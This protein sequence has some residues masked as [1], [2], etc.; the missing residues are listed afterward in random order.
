MISAMAQRSP[1]ISYEYKTYLLI[2]RFI[3]ESEVSAV[4]YLVNR[5]D[6]VAALMSASG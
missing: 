3:A 6:V 5:K 1:V 4:L 2:R